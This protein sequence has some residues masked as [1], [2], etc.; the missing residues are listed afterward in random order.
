M[1]QQQILLIIHSDM[2]INKKLSKIKNF[3]FLQSNFILIKIV[4]IV[5]V[6]TVFATSIILSHMTNESSITL[7]KS[8]PCLQY[9]R[10]KMNKYKLLCRH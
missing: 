5:F 9:T 1:R 3:S 7:S 8:L 10:I 4:G 2:I 6:G